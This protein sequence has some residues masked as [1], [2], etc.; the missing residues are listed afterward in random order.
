[1]YD[2][3]L[4]S[5]MTGGQIPSNL[6]LSLDFRDL[7]LVICRE[8]IIWCTPNHSDRKVFNSP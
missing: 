5:P 2:S 7:N 6:K 8:S 1:M 3:V 4:A